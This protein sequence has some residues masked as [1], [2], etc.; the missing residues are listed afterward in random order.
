M[1]KGLKDMHEGSIVYFEGLYGDMS[2]R[3][4]EDYEHSRSN[5]PPG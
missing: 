1:T 4:D 2:R 3:T 5:R